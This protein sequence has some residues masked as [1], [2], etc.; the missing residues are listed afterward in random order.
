MPPPPPMLDGSV[1]SRLGSLPHRVGECTL[2][3]VKGKIK[4][5]PPIPKITLPLVK[6]KIKDNPPIPIITLP[7]VKGKIK[8]NPPIPKI[9]LP[10]V[11]RGKTIFKNS[12]PL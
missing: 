10:P 2:V 9:T 1:A 7:L 12:L 5:N 3:L 11:F 6:G 8:D 4:D